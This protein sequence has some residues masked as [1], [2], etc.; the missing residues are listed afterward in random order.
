MNVRINDRDVKP[1]KDASGIWLC[2]I[3][4]QLSTL[5]DCMLIYILVILVVV[6]V[7][8]CN[9]CDFIK[10]LSIFFYVYTVSFIHSH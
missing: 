7:I 1:Q 4:V 9:N 3:V 5:A 2:S 6:S 8:L 10:Q